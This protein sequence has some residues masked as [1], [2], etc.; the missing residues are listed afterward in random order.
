MRNSIKFKIWQL[1]KSASGDQ[2]KS[3]FSKKKF[4]DVK[5]LKNV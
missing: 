1:K 3:A 5:K 2:T 4:F